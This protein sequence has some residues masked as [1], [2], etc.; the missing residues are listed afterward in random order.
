[1]SDWKACPK[2]GQR[3]PSHWKK[4]FAC[5]WVE[6]QEQEPKEKPEE[7]KELEEPEIKPATETR[8][9]SSS[10]VQMFEDIKARLDEIP[11]LISETIEQNN[12]EAHFAELNR[13]LDTLVA[14][15]KESNTKQEKML[16][17]FMMNHFQ[18]L[19]KTLPEFLKNKE[20]KI[21]SA[22]EIVKKIKEEVNGTK[23]E[24]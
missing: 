6:G 10:A 13:K 22:E 9:V 21:I 1:M 23:E 7:P 15:I 19:S 5:G 17:K 2:C 14:E 8:P 24:E 4:H 11:A 20:I 12:Y 16:E 18:F 3:I